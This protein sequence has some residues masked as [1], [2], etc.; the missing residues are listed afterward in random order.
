[1][2]AATQPRMV[3]SMPAHDA[4]RRHPIQAISSLD[5]LAV[6]WQPW[7]KARNTELLNSA[8]VGKRVSGCPLTS[9]SSSRNTGQDCSSFCGAAPHEGTVDAT[10]RQLHQQCGAGLGVQLQVDTR[11]LPAQLRP[12]VAEDAV[13]PWFPSS[14]CARRP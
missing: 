2:P 3:S 13:R 7:R 5:P 11:M 14:L 8:A 12:A 4:Y 6:S 9:T 10:S 1:M